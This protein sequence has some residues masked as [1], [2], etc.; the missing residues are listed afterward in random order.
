MEDFA[1]VYALNVDPQERQKREIDSTL[2]TFSEKVVQ[3]AARR[4]L[5]Y[6]EKHLY[7]LQGVLKDVQML[8]TTEWSL[9]ED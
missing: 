3:E 7:D 6:S 9:H 1:Q 5:V 8:Y 4:G 2:E